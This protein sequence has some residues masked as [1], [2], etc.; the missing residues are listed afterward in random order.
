MVAKFE[1]SGINEAALFTLKTYRGERMVLLAMNWKTETP[2]DDF[3]GFAIEY[4]E[5]N[6]T[7]FFAV[8]NRISFPGSVS[9]YKHPS[10]TSPIQMFRWVH[11]PLNP[12]LD[13]EFI[14]RVIP[15]FMNQNDILSYGEPQETK[16][17]LGR[18]TYP[19]VLNVAFT[20]GFISSQ[21]FVDKY[22]KTGGV[23]SLLPAKADDGLGYISTNVKAEQ[24]YAWMGFEARKEILKVLDE[25]IADQSAKVSVV[26]YDLNEPEIVSRLEK[27]QK[28]LRIIIDSSGTH[29]KKTSAESQAEM[30]LVATA[31]QDQVIRQKM[32]NLQHNKTIVVD[33]TT[34]QRVVCGS[35]NFSW[36]A[37]Y[38]QSNNALILTGTDAVKVYQAAFESYRTV[39]PKDFG[40][41]A[42]AAQWHELNL[43]NLDAKVT[44]SPHHPDNGLLQTIADDI[45]TNISSSLLYS[46]AFL[47][48]T[49]GAVTDAITKITQNDNIFVYGISDKKV[50]GGLD[51]QEPKGNVSP[52]YAAELNKNLPKPFSKEPSGGVGTRMHHKFL[53][54]DFDKPTARVWVGSYNYSFPADQENGEN[55]LLIKDRKIA[56]SY[57]IEALSIF[58]HYSF[59]VAQL[60]AAKAKK[61]L[62][63]LRPPKNPGEEPWWKKNYT[64]SRRIRD[65][66]LFA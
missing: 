54:L 64:E 48:E 21:E 53:V 2:P 27:L 16:I 49:P 25:A 43:N 29:G 51:I 1:V 24:A 20:R 15:V 32:L 66:L 40:G 59:R 19:G 12:D 58:D 44:F 55:L 60:D 38:I 34:I 28:R 62:T 9:T 63:L 22:D 23:S 7:N 6:G 4:K 18:E 41:S 17:I 42:P 5:P 26:A 14:Y 13:G 46:L 57:M 37:F 65:R 45:S 35:T 3:V 10:R 30:R 11:F 47:Y 36:R 61:Q 33:G 8:S 39:K 50:G 52:V 56:V 31:G